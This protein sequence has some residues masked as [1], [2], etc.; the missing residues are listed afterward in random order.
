MSHGDNGRLTCGDVQHQTRKRGPT[1]TSPKRG[2][3][4]TCWFHRGVTVSTYVVHTL[5]LGVAFLALL[6]LSCCLPR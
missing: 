6:S 1:L 5:S 4:Q 3:V 2:D